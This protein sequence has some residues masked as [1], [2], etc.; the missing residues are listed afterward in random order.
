MFTSVFYRKKS[1]NNFKRN[2]PN[3][4]NKNL[5]KIVNSIVS[6]LLTG[7]QSVQLLSAIEMS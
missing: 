2:V 7:G 3:L 5:P 6:N 4:F 1:V